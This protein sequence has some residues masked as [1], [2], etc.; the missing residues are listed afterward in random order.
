MAGTTANNSWPYPESSDFVAD[1]ATAIENLADAIDTDLGTVS[2][3]PL[4]IVGYD[5][6]NSNTAITTST[7]TVLSVTATLKSGRNYFIGVSA[8][9][10][11]A[12]TSQL[13]FSIIEVDGTRVN[14][15]G[16]TAPAASAHTNLTHFTH[17]VPA[18]DQTSVAITADF[19]VSAGTNTVAGQ[20]TQPTVLVVYDL[21]A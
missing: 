18:S 9:T 14:A 5:T 21:G 2:N 6:K 3:L 17:Y 20:S 15:L 12:S 8:Y 11:N 16:V 13:V 1:G 4:G 7:T 10:F 19:S